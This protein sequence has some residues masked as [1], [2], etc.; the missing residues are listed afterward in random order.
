MACFG[1]VDGIRNPPYTHGAKT[2]SRPS[3]SRYVTAPFA[4]LYGCGVGAGRSPAFPSTGIPLNVGRRTL[5]LMT[6]AGGGPPRGTRVQI[7]VPSG[8]VS[9]A[10]AAH[11]N[12]P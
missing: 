11:E 10:S 9:G 12:R 4:A 1:P 6:A 2:T 3:G 8:A 7:A 5:A